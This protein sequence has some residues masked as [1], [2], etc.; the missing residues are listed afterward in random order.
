M[1]SDREL[2]KLEPKAGSTV[3]RSQVLFCEAGCR[4][5]SDTGLLTVQNMQHEVNCEVTE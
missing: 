2:N 3:T 1:H 5:K 4:V